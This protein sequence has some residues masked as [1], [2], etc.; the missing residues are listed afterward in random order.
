MTVSP[1]R[2]QPLPTSLHTII[3]SF[4]DA[5][6]DLLTPLK[7]HINKQIKN[8]KQRLYSTKMTISNGVRTGSK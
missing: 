1:I 5:H 7:I 2:L 4:K 6:P 3:L 8:N